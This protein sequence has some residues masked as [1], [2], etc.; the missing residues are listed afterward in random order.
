MLILYLQ[1]IFC[2]SAQSFSNEIGLQYDGIQQIFSKIFS[3]YK[4]TKELDK[5]VQNYEQELL[6]YKT[7]LKNQNKN[8][9]ES[10]FDFYD[11]NLHRITS[12]RPTIMDIQKKYQKLQEKAS[13]ETRNF[14]LK[15]LFE[16][17]KDLEPLEKI[18]KSLEKELNKYNKV[19][20]SLSETIKGYLENNDLVPSGLERLYT[21]EE[22][23]KL[24]FEY[25]QK[26]HLEN[27]LKIAKELL[28]TINSNEVL[29]SNDIKLLSTV[30]SEHIFNKNI[31]TNLINKGKY[32]GGHVF[33]VLTMYLAISIK[34]SVFHIYDR[35]LETKFSEEGINTGTFKK[36]FSL[37]LSKEEV[38]NMFKREA[39]PGHIG[40]LAFG[41][42]HDIYSTIIN[43][44]VT[45]RLNSLAF[46]NK[47]LL[48]R[49]GV[50][51]LLNSFNHFAGMSISMY[52]ASVVSSY[53]LFK[54]DDKDNYKEFIADYEKEYGVN[55]REFVN[56]IDALSDEGLKSAAFGRENLY[57]VLKISLSFEMAHILLNKLKYSTH[58]KKMFKGSFN[59][60]LTVDEMLQFYLNT[61]GK[62]NMV[63]RYF[64]N[65]MVT[66]ALFG[67]AEI[68]E[69]KLF[70]EKIDLKK[71]NA[72]D[73]LTF[74]YSEL[75]SEI[76]FRINE[77]YLK[78][79][80]TKWVLKKTS[81][82]KDA[83]TDIVNY[84][85]N[86]YDIF[87]S[88]EVFKS[89][90]IA[91]TLVGITKENLLDD[92]NTCLS[93]EEFEKFKDCMLDTL[94]YKNR[95]EY[96]SIIIYSMPFS[97]YLDN[98]L[99]EYENIKSKLLDY[100]NEIYDRMIYTKVFYY[101]LKKAEYEK[102]K[103]IFDKTIFYD[104][105]K[106]KLKQ[107]LFNEILKI[108]SKGNFKSIKDIEKEIIAIIKILLKSSLFLFESNWQLPLYLENIEADKVRST[109]RTASELFILFILEGLSKETDFNKLKIELLDVYDD[110]SRTA[111]RIGEEEF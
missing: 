58:L 67:V 68:I 85:K 14:I 18:I 12:G 105:T 91:S 87:Q 49:V 17:V 48:R 46:V 23:E 38:K 88:L 25:K 11:F 40:F 41:F 75:F 22:L 74:L 32:I 53:L 51:K 57:S 37:E 96:I 97:S 109:D 43:A 35:A 8:Y 95:L 50:F 34:N 82:I 30:Y 80:K 3:D 81:N 64:K 100:E 76:I 13:I 70:E 52:A 59:C 24:G 83:E 28:K 93:F 20:F 9:K 21:F 33:S 1:I 26:K 84:N 7:K 108:K 60:M 90:Y 99:E 10:D 4:E 111:S 69:R 36:I 31:S 56:Q 77:E 78:D 15:K 102:A 103:N 29:S 42:V 63:G 86:L 94:Y 44:G 71:D 72:I 61:V 19:Y 16:K 73:K 92:N 2:L 55:V 110:L 54:R 47:T 65:L 106:A 6:L 107:K 62:T 39:V 101:Y 89:S 98:N 66:T 104:S 27:H 45:S 79:K 5:L